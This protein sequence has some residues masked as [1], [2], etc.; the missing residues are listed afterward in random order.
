MLL[1]TAVLVLAAVAKVLLS[2]KVINISCSSAGLICSSRGWQQGKEP[3]VGCSLDVQ[4]E[5]TSV[6]LSAL[7]SVIA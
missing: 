6:E 1:V 3:M 5:E 4:L 7:L 2:C